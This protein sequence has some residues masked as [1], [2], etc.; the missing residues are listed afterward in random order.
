MSG[1]SADARTLVDHARSEAQYHRFTYNEP[2]PVES[3]TQS[4]CDL[5]LGFGESEGSK[6]AR[7][8]GVALLIAGWD[9]SGPTLFHTDPSGTYTKFGA[10]AIGAGAEGAQTA[11][12]EQYHKNLTLEEAETMAVTILKQVM[13]EKLDAS[14]VEVASVRMPTREAPAAP[15]AACHYVPGAAFTPAYTTYGKE[16]LEKVLARV[17]ADSTATA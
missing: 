4:V 11:L 12:Q 9:L 8:F 16:E 6:M 17:N 13:E 2:M 15:G 14:N 5:A 7:P 10:K 3:L 1:L